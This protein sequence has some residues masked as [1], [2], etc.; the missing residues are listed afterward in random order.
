MLAIN[1]DRRRAHGHEGRLRGDRRPARDRAR[2]RRR[3]AARGR[4]TGCDSGHGARGPWTRAGEAAQDEPHRL[5]PTISCRGVWKVFGP[6][7]ERVVGSAD[8]DLPAPSSRRAP[9]ASPRSATSASTC[10]RG[11]RVRG[12]GTVGLGQ[13]DARA[14]PVSRLIE[15]TAGTVLIDGEDVAAARPERLRELRRD[16]RVD[17]VPALRAA[18][19]PPR[20]RQRRVRPRGA[21]QVE[22]RPRSRRRATCS[23]SSGS[24]VSARAI[25]TSCRAA[26]SNGSASPARSPT[27]PR[28]CSSTSR[29][30]RSTR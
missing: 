3:A 8:A 14:L 25:P 1:T 16:R 30:P 11:E 15:P 28:S 23:T 29:S 27:T 10:P 18:P 9:A 26:C 24:A 17:G 2:D 20:A 13:V 5:A 19:P 4:L 21:G 12:D 22:G 6:H 7:P